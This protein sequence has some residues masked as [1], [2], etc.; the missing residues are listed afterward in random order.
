MLV[1]ARE[2][3]TAGTRISRGR[4]LLDPLRNG[5]L[6]IGRER[7]EQSDSTPDRPKPT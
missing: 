2:M 1:L 4:G 6:A 5:T 3:Q 7:I